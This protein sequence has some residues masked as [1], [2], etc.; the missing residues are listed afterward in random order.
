MKKCLIITSYIEGE[1]SELIRGETFDCILCAD[2]G[3]DYAK[4]SCITPD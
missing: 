3:Y 4:K 1:L 2:G